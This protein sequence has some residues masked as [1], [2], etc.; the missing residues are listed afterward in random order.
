[1]FDLT[2]KRA[3]VTGAAGGVGAEVARRLHEHGATVAL[4][5]RRVGALEALAGELGGR[6]HVLPCDLMDEAAVIALPRQARAAMGGVDIL[7]NCAGI[8]HDRSILRMSRQDWREVMAVNMDAPMLL[9]QGVLRDMLKA[10]WGRIISVTSVAGSM[11]TPGQ[12]NY[13]AS[14]AGVAGMT[15]SIAQE[16]ASRG[17]TANVV[18]PGMIDTPMVEVLTEEQ[19]NHWVELT[20]VGRMASVTEIAAAVIYLASPE[21]AY[22]TGA[23]LQVNGGLAMR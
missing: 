23:V 3:L 22:V 12:A 15:R 6:C 16:V 11:G 20:P 7:V 2:G 9:C 8:V 13:A 21:A 4:S 1:M 5:D 10:H 19:L 14:K 18:A 17:V